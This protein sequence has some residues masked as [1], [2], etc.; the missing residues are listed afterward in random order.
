[1]PADTRGRRP[2]V[3]WCHPPRGADRAGASRETTSLMMFI[4]EPLGCPTGGAGVTSR[5]WTGSSTTPTRSRRP[6]RSL[7]PPARDPHRPGRLRQA[8]APSPRRGV[9]RHRSRRGATC[10]GACPVLQDSWAAS[11]PCTPTRRPPGPSSEQAQAAAYRR[12]LELGE[13]PPAPRR[14]PLLPPSRRSL[15]GRLA[16]RR[17]LRGRHAEDEPLVRAGGRRKTPRPLAPPRALQLDPP[18]PRP[19][20]ASACVTEPA[21]D[22]TIACGPPGCRPSSTASRRSTGSTSSRRCSR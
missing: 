5:S 7:S 15:A 17:P 19:L 4:R 11:R 1:M 2:C 21:E 14:R 6:C 13:L 9:R 20:L 3:G 16:V 18:P 8:R 12:T 10:R 22:A